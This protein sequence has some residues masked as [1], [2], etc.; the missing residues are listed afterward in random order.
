MRFGGK[1]SKV[2]EEKDEQKML[3]W[4]E[5]KALKEKKNTYYAHV[6]PSLSDHSVKINGAETELPPRLSSQESRSFAFT[7]F[8]SVLPTFFTT[9]PFLS[10]SRFVLHCLLW[11]LLLASS[12]WM[13]LGS[14]FVRISRANQG[15]HCSELP[16]IWD[17]NLVQSLVV[18]F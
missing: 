12:G 10:S 5:R 2:N 13:P 16:F 15:F 11:I 9:F 3:W 17:Q 4:D 8:L 14:F 1:I 6:R 18:K 7:T